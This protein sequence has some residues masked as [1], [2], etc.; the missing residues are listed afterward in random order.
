[1]CS[2]CFVAFHIL[3]FLCR[4]YFCLYYKSLQI[5]GSLAAFFANADRVP[6]NF[7]EVYFGVSQILLRAFLR[8]QFR[9]PVADGLFHARLFV[10]IISPDF[11]FFNMDLILKMLGQSV[12]QSTYMNDWNSLWLQGK[13]GVVRRTLTPSFQGSNPCSPAT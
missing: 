4:A 2:E 11:S 8:Q 9:L 1:M 3:K 7:V 6:E 13:S 5:Q 12:G 10:T